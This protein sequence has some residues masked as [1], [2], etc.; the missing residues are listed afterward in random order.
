[1]NI[2]KHIITAF[3]KSFYDYTWVAAQRHSLMRAVVYFF[4]FFFVVVGARGWFFMKSAPAA[5]G[6]HWQTFETTLPDFSIEKTDEG[7]TVLGIEQPY[8]QELEEDGETVIVYVDTV[9]TSSISMEDV[10]GEYDNTYAVLITSKKIKFFDP[11]T[12][13]TEVEDIGRLPNFS[14]T[15]AQ[16]GEEITQWTDSLF[17]GLYLLGVFLFTLFLGAGKLIYALLLSWFIYVMARSDKKA[18]KYGEVF[19]ISL[20]AL[21]LP[22]LIEW[23]I[24]VFYTGIPFLYSI[25]ILGIM[26]AIVYKSDSDTPVGKIDTPKV[27]EPPKK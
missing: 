4:V 5:I 23:A 15:K 16:I 26:Y 22:I 25:L 19:T 8:T 13:R 10:L 2:F 21:T 12:G 24:S 1:M 27:P 11:E 20:Y 3:Y 18:W 7:F 17:P 6:E 9:S 14:F